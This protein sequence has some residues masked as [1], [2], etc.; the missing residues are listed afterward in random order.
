VKLYRSRPVTVEVERFDLD[1]GPVYH[2]RRSDG[3]YEWLLME[4][5]QL[6]YEPVFGDGWASVTRREEN[7]D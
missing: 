1:W 3:S 6:K 7:H 5:L 2:V 4:E